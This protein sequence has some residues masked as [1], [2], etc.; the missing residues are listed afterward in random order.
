MYGIKKLAED[1]PK[2]TQ[3][4]HL[5]EA[6]KE[7]LRSLAAAGTGKQAK[8]MAL[9]LTNRLYEKVGTEDDDKKKDMI[10]VFRGLNAEKVEDLPG[11]VTSFQL[12]GDGKSP[13]KRINYVA[14]IPEEG[15]SA[16]VRGFHG[17]PLTS[18][19]IARIDSKHS[20][21]SADRL[22]Q[23]SP[24]YRGE[25]TFA[26]GN[27]RFNPTSLLHELG[28]ATGSERTDTIKHKAIFANRIL[29]AASN[30]RVGQ[31]KGTSPHSPVIAPMIIAA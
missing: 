31:F 5:R 15:R 30:V 22:I 10:K 9:S 17:E 2:K 4:S 23:A 29:G 28:H 6:M 3:T 19:D 1:K 16:F 25:R 21:K 7:G 18:E 8:D 12:K 26:I 11:G 14:D 24:R 13:G 27:T 20:L